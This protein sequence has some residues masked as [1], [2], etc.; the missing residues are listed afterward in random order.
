MSRLIVGCPV[1]SRAWSLPTWFACLAAQTRRPDGFVFIHSG[2]PHDETWMVLQ[3]EAARHQFSPVVLHHNEAPPHPRHDNERFRTLVGLRNEMLRVAR[4]GLGADLLLSLDTDVMFEDPHTIERL[5][6]MLDECDVASPVT[7]LHPLASRPDADLS[8]PCWAY[9]AGWW[10]DGDTLARPIPE[11]LPWGDTLRI[12]I[13][14]AVWLGNRQAMDCRYAHHPSGE[15][16]GFAQDLREHGLTCLW[17]TSLRARH[18]W[19]E[20]DL[21]PEQVAA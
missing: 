3:R 12:D 5:V 13:P 14:M 2:A 8:Q 9:N 7:F 20:Q 19:C 1:A 11:Q 21:L 17:D 15:D 10:G 18:V 6:E 4:D 16:L